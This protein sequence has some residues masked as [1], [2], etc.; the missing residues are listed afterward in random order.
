MALTYDSI[1]T[2]TVTGSPVGT[3]DFNSIPT[4]FTD[5]RLILRGAPTSFGQHQM[6]FNGS[7]V[8]TYYTNII[9]TQGS[10]DQS[11]SSAPGN[12]QLILDGANGSGETSAFTIVDIFNYNSTTLSKNVLCQASAV[13]S[14]SGQV[15]FV[16]G[17]WRDTSA[18]TSINLKCD[19]TNTFPVGFVVA[20]YGIKAA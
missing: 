15:F 20:L 10:S 12:A 1:A 7:S 18:I 3:I 19:F 8:S 13:Q 6:R 9:R 16:N 14:G 4:T 11:F 2:Q 17:L 5:L